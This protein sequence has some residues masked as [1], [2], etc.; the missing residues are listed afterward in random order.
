VCIVIWHVLLL[1]FVRIEG[2]GGG[3]SALLTAV[4]IPDLA[5][6]LAVLAAYGAMTSGS[7]VTMSAVLLRTAEAEFRGRVMGVRMMAVYGLPMGLLLGGYLSERFGVLP[8]LEGLG[9]VGLGLTVGAAFKWP[10]LL[11]GA[12]TVPVVLRP[13]S[14]AAP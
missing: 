13:A 6:P 9:I 12:R 1:V 10:E 5:L 8:A 4:G 11:R 7:M 3:V 2:M 14:A